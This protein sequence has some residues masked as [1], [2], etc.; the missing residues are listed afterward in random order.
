MFGRVR[1][2]ENLDM[3]LGE[4]LQRRFRNPAELPVVRNQSYRRVGC[5]VSSEARYDSVMPH[6]TEAN[7]P[8]CAYRTCE[9]SLRLVAGLI[10]SSSRKGSTGY[11]VVAPDPLTGREQPIWIFQEHRR[12]G[13]NEHEANS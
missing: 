10:E 5:V 3:V 2:M 12:V 13:L 8:R 4:L 11:V 7:S 1:L 6:E 9:D